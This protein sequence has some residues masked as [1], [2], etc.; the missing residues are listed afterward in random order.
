MGENSPNL[1]ALFVLSYLSKRLR[2]SFYLHI[3]AVLLDGFLTLLH[4]YYPTP[5]PPTV[6]Q[7]R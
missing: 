4:T 1:I 7:F 2:I 6:V 3:P 5:P